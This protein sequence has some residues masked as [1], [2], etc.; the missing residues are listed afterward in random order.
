MPVA[1]IPST[2]ADLLDRPL[3]ATLATV[4]PDGRPQLTVVWF[5]V[6]EVGLSINTERGR[7]KTANL[8][9]DGRATLLIVDPDDQHR[10]L[11]LRCDVTSVSEHGA[12]AH[13][14]RID[15]RYL[16]PDHRTDP[17]GDAGARVIVRLTPV[18][19]NASG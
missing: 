5:E 12:L 11:E 10:Y 14:A 3:P 2:H 9:R 13:R 16:G 17:A 8:E 4:Q 6:D 18:R 1:R 19:V 15:R 7:R